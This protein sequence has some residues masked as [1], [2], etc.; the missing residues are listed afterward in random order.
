MYWFWPV[1]TER[2]QCNHTC[3]GTG[4]FSSYTMKL[5]MEF[6]TL[7]SGI[8]VQYWLQPRI[9]VS[10]ALCLIIFSMSVLLSRDWPSEG[11]LFWP[12]TQ[13]NDPS[14][15][16]N[17]QIQLTCLHPCCHP[18]KI[19]WW[20]IWNVTIVLFVQYSYAISWRVSCK[21]GVCDILG[22]F[23]FFVGSS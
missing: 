1:I 9:L 19:M 22:Q 18:I 21:K 5:L 15:D 12:W 11:E 16:M 20:L 3:Q 13:C 6:A 7:C 23:L 17:R 8:L 2:N 10:F 4:I 14:Q